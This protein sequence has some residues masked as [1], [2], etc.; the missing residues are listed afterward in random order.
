MKLHYKIRE[1]E[2]TV[3][4]VNVMSLYSYVCKYFKFP[5]GHPAIHVGDACQDTE[6]MLRKE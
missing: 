6:A 1:G 2:E 4:Y 3:Q 5:L